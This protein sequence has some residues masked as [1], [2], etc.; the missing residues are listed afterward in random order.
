LGA[1]S[2]LLCV[3]L[4]LTP[5][6]D[7]DVRASAQTASRV[8]LWLKIDYTAFVAALVPVYCHY[9]GPTILLYFCNIALLLAL[10]AIWSENALLI[11]MCAVGMVIPQAIWVIDFVS[12][13]IGF[14]LA[15]MTSY[16]FDASG[17][18][19]FRMLSLFHGWLPFLLIY[20]VRSTGYDRRGFWSWTVLSWGVLLICFFVMP[21]PTPN[22]GLTPVNINYVWGLSYTAAQTW[23]SPTVWL[24]GL[25]VGLP[26]FVFAPAHF[27]MTRASAAQSRHVN[28]VHDRHSHPA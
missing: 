3:D 26:L 9:Y 17:S 22:P 27:L 14:P 21:P 18:L 11:S 20:L 19:L 6:S 25:L 15:G 8:P 10:L 13:A 4:P 28:R 24:V 23:M 2:T 5:R 12:V 1:H 7:T 16:M